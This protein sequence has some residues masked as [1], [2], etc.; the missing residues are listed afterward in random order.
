MQGV[1][2]QEASDGTQGGWLL[3]RGSPGKADA[4]AVSGK[5]QRQDGVAAT[6]EVE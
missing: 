1:G 5:R 2:L 4:E 6:V 3:W